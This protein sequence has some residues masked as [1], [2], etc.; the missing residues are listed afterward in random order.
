MVLVLGP[1]LVLVNTLGVLF[2]FISVKYSLGGTQRRL[3]TSEIGM[4]RFLSF[5]WLCVCVGGGGFGG[6]KII[7]VFF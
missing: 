4:Q 3:V 1:E 2:V 5:S 6:R 7:A